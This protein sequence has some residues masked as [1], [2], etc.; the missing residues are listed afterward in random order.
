MKVFDDLVC[1]VERNRAELLKTIKGKQ[2]AAEQQAEEF[3][4]ELEEEIAE[5]K[6]RDTELKQLSHTEDHIHFLQVCTSVFLRGNGGL[7]MAALIS[8]LSC[9]VVDVLVHVQP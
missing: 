1:Y 4:K 9:C 3:I 2:R 8:V 7:G 5:L 6:R